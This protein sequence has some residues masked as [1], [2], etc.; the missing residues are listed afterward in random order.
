MTP[1]EIA[2]RAAVNKSLQQ[3]GRTV[4]WEDDK[5]W[6]PYENR[7][8]ATEIVRA[9]LLALAECDIPVDDDGIQV[10]IPMLGKMPLDKPRLMAFRAILRSIASEGK[11]N[12]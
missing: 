12:D 5:E 4:M 3:T 8:K 11:D 1:L 9:A 7:Q 2:T 6:P 10:K